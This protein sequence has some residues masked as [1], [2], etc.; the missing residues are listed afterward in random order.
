MINFAEFKKFFLFNLIGS[1][2]VAA[3]VAVITVLSKTF[4]EVTLRVFFTLAMVVVHSLVSLSFIWDDKR[5][6]TFERLS[7]FI[8]IL[9]IIIV[10]SFF[11]SILG[12]WEIIPGSIIAKMYMTYFVLLFAALHGDIL[13][14]ALNKETYLDLIVYLNYVFMAFVVIML[15]IIIYT[16]NALRVLGEFFFRGLGAIAIIDGTLSVLTIIFYKIY[17]NKHPR[18]ENLLQAGTQE[19]KKKG[20]SIWVWILIIYL[21]IQVIS[22]LIFFGS[23]IFGI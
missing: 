21:V 23:R 1:L 16:D 9:F 12:I 13:S 18:V 17:M 11:T 3:L 15:Q 22:P 19:Q 10:L 7:F 4:N 8:N 6:N 14:K 5:Q 2:I 20:L